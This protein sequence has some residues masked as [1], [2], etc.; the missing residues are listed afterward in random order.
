MIQLLIIAVF[1]TFIW[2]NIIYTDNQTWN[3]VRENTGSQQYIK[4]H[5]TFCSKNNHRYGSHWYTSNRRRF[6]RRTPTASALY[7]TNPT[8]GHICTHIFLVTHH[9]PLLYFFP[10][11]LHL[12]GMTAPTC[13]LWIIV[14]LFNHCILDKY[15]L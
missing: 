8:H 7:N 2:N 11:G 10:V 3:G 12:T 5:L 6:Q 9:I 14:G 4:I 15:A 1:N 13:P